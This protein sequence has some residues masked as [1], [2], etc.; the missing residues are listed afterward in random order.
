[1]P[2]RNGVLIMIRPRKRKFY[3]YL[4]E[5]YPNIFDY[6]QFEDNIERKKEAKNES[7]ICLLDI[8]QSA[9][10]DDEK[11]T[12]LLETTL[13]TKTDRLILRNTMACKGKELTPIQLDQYISIIEYAI[14]YIY[15]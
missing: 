10:D 5:K 11:L 8:I 4:E 15:S 14:E 3:S 6:E 7:Y 1:M 2:N 9:N 13:K 12:Q